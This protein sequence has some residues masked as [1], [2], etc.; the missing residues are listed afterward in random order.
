VDIEAQ[1]QRSPGG[2]DL[3]ARQRVEAVV[4][5]RRR[6]RQFSVSVVADLR[7]SDYQLRP[8]R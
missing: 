8:R 5:Q 2:L 3:A 6:L 4:Q 1:F 7:F